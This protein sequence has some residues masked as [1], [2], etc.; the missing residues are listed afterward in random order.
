M[1]IG[2]IRDLVGDSAEKG[3]KNSSDFSGE[4]RRELS[5]GGMRSAKAN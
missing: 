1:Q 4:R 5:S 2:P 3:K